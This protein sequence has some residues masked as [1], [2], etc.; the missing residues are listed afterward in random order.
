M[1]E[2]RRSKRFVASLAAGTVIGAV[3][4]VLAISFAALVFGGRLTT[5]LPDGIGLYLV[6]GGLS[7][8]LLGWLAGERGSVG[9]VQ[10]A[11]AAV[12]AVIATGVVTGISG[13][14][15][16]AFLTVVAA[17][18]VVT[19]L[20]GVTFL[21][22]GTFR[23]GNLIRFVP[24]PVIG[25]FLAG[26]GWLL[27]KGGLGVAAGIQ[28]FLRTI[29]D[30]LTLESMER[31]VPALV[32]GIAILVL[33]RV[34]TRPI[35]IPAAIG[36]G[37][38]LFAIG[39]V[40]T[41]S[42]L[43]DA[44]AGGW[45]LGPFPSARLWQPWT[46]R[47][48]SGADWPAVL[49]QAA[50]ICTAIFV[51]LMATLFNVSGVELM[52]HKDLDSNRELRDAGILNIASGALG[53]IPG[54]HT[55]SLTSLAQRMNTSARSASLV[56]ALVPLAAVVFGASLVE[57]IPR[58][59]LGGVLAFIGL[60]FIVEWAFDTR[61][62]LP[63][64]EYLIVLAILAT[65]VAK[66]FLPGVVLGLVL[67]VVLFAVNYSRIELI[68]E[69]AFGDAYH[70]NVDRPS[71]ERA[72]LR[73][74]ADRVQIL[75]LQGFVFF[76]TASGLLDRIHVR[77][78][79]GP[80]R[81]MLLEL[82]GV[83]AMDASAVLAFGKAVQLA[84]ANGAQ[85]V[86]AGASEPV[87]RQLARGGVVAAEG[88]LAFEPDLDRALQRCEDGLLASA[89][90][91]AADVSPDGSGEPLAG[92]PPQLSRYLERVSLAEGTVLIRQDEPPDDV[93]VLESGRLRV[94]L[95]TPEGR[96]MRL[97]TMRPGV[98]VGEIAMYMR[99]PRTADVIAETPS[100]VLRLRRVSIERMESEEPELAAALHR[101]LARTLAERLSDTLKAFDAL[102]D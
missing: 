100:V 86:L 94:E 36:I 64:G 75:R 16:R 48:L 31:W 67:A 73:A 79:R 3:V 63:I 10:D 15:D 89:P 41:G 6:A 37:L 46:V 52:L 72:T 88:L 35:V 62:A 38:V 5:H 49:E 8:G 20:T 70:S 30:L 81:Y 90:E 55:L 26:T 25:G 51:A 45:L 27:F 22:V 50:G 96:R 54:F 68:H 65:I 42:T 76:G 4:V 34:L 53:G 77:L 23:L 60:A 95:E 97:R 61:R 14:L 83:T 44:L 13:N 80:L 9:S 43:D 56:A 74:L 1:S 101:W 69:V 93:F 57:L 2:Q 11:P 59:I 40:A 78:A 12:L 21:V 18:L 19:L 84:E 17:T 28:P 29:D 66:G 87:S 39:M 91:S 102:L 98:V 47:A 58:M 7:L 24:Y 32:F 82:R 33:T 99:V 92:L 71:E 85:L